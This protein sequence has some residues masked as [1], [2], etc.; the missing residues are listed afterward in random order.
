MH[1]FLSF[2]LPF[3]ISLHKSVLVVQQE[4]SVLSSLSKSRMK[5]V[6][7]RFTPE[8]NEQNQLVRKDDWVNGIC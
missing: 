1:Y 6:T 3:L 7:L 8:L 2:D 4:S 5:T